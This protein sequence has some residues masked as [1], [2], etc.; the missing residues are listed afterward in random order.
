[1]VNDC[2]DKIIILGRVVKKKVC[3]WIEFIL[4]KLSFIY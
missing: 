4:Y 2:R 1:M 3:N